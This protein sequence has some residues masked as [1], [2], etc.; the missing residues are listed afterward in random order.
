MKNVH[1]H[2][3]VRLP[4]I[5]QLGLDALDAVT[6]GIDALRGIRHL[7]DGAEGTTV[8]DKDV[9]RDIAREVRVYDTRVKTG[10][11][12]LDTILTEKALLGEREGITMSCIVDGKVL[13]FMAP[14]DLYALFGNAIEN[15]FEAVRQ[16]DDPEK[17]NISV[18]VKRVAN[19]VSIHVEN[20]YSGSVLFDGELPVSSKAD[21][22]NHGYGMRS[23]KMIC[24]RY[25]GALAASVEG[26]VFSLDA[27]IPIS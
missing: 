24:E 18:L 10:N 8:L 3:N 25:G 11:D 14:T 15:S 6:E 4:G 13:D 20:Y 23:M 26:Q 9:L 22:E 21:A 7:E 27:L 19:M 17:R 5:R 16:V 2:I 1:I 12:A